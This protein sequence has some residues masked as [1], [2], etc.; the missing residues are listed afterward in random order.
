MKKV[1]WAFAMVL[2]QGAL[3]KSA[4][5]SWK[6]TPEVKRRPNQVQV[7]RSDSFD[8]MVNC[9][10]GSGST[11]HEANFENFY[12][13]SHEVFASALQKRDVRSMTLF[14]T[15]TTEI[16]HLRDCDSVEAE[17]AKKI[18]EGTPQCFETKGLNSSARKGFLF[19]DKTNH[20]LEIQVY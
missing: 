5:V 3:A 12:S 1:L 2:S 6:K 9:Y 4:A 19:F 10:N 11:G 16:S 13:C 8:R 17:F 15:M 20:L 14:L 18:R 7:E